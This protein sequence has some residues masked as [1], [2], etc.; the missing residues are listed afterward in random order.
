MVLALAL[1][2][3][4]GRLTYTCPVSLSTPCK[5]VVVTSWSWRSPSLLLLAFAL[6]TD[7]TVVS[8]DSAP[9]CAPHINT[10]LVG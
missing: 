3:Q 5:F 8:L 4:E 1:C 6:S 10:L 7:G 9:V 2:L